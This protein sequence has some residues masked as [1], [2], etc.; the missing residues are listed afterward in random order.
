MKS[1]NNFCFGYVTYQTITNEKETTEMMKF[2]LAILLIV[3]LSTVYCMPPI[4]FICTRR[5]SDGSCRTHSVLST[6]EVQRMSIDMERATRLEDEIPAIKYRQ[7]VKCG[8][9]ESKYGLCGLEGQNPQPGPYQSFMEDG[10]LV[11]CNPE[12]GFSV[13]FS[14]AFQCDQ[15]KK[16]AKKL[17]CSGCNH[18]VAYIE[19]LGKDCT[20][21]ANK[22]G[23][24]LDLENEW[25]AA[26][27]DNLANTC[28]NQLQCTC[29]PASSVSRTVS[30]S[31]KV[32]TLR[33]ENIS[34]GGL[35]GFGGQT[36]MMRV[37][38]Q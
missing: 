28:Q 16:S 1:V 2:S 15:L 36:R 19:S 18:P 37:A 4:P 26:F 5:N 38:L 3:V 23:G 11:Q 17:A 31:G 32:A 21:L 13:R 29:T 12:T 10:V 6:A 7:Y 24:G 34:L 8:P 33:S 22:Y 25:Y 30:Y 20:E 27:L 14:C 9:C 35:K